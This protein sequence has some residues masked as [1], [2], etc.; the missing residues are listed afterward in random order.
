MELKVLGSVSPVIVD[1]NNCPGYLVN[2]NLLLDIGSGVNRYLDLPNVLKDLNIIITHLHR[3]H[4]LDLYGIIYLVKELKKDKNIDS[5]V[6]V[7]IPKKPRSIFKDI[8]SEALNVINI[9]SYNEK[10]KLK[11]NGM[12]IDFIKVKH[13]RSMPSYAVRIRCDKTLIYTA[14]ASNYSKDDLISFSRN[15]DLIISDSKF[16]H[17]NGIENN[18]YHLTSYEASIIAREANVKQ[19]LLT[20]LPSLCENKSDYLEEAKINFKNTQVL[21][22]KMVIKL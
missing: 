12:N 2:N 13:T 19:L 5:C 3:D 7:Y 15:A 18:S 21:E 8:K 14:D 4:Y 16:L 22:A 10:T 11:I 1:N 9:H 20:H 6:N 17:K